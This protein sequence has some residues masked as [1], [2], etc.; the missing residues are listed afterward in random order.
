LPRFISQA[1]EPEAGSFDAQSIARGEPSLPSAFRWGD[2]HLVVARRLKAWRTTKVD[3]ADT[4]V[5]RHWFE[6]E[7]P[8][9]ATVTVYFHR[10]A[11]RGQPRWWLYT[12]DP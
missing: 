5:D 6:F 1:I 3:R 2:Q 4:Y 11:S 9:G 12:I 10:R 7:T 8:D